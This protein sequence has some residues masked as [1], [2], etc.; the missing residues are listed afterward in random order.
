[1]NMSQSPGGYAQDQGWILD[2]FPRTKKEA[3][4]FVRE[5]ITPT[6]LLVFEDDTEGDDL[7]TR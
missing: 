4:W 6:N 3:E 2:G 7:Q 5:G 1:M